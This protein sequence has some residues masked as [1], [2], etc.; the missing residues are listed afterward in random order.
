M[1]GP[2]VCVGGVSHVALPAAQ[3]HEDHRHQ[4]HHCQASKDDAQQHCV[5]SSWREGGAVRATRG[6]GGERR[7]RWGWA[8]VG[9]G[10]AS[11]LGWHV[12]VG[13]DQVPLA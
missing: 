3:H 13:V 5:A 12:G 4:S 11:S 1:V 10:G 7:G 2:W 8:R 9:A 6:G